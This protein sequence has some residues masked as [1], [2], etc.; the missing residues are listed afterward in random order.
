MGAGDDAG[1]GEGR[2]VAEG[3]L[4]LPYFRDGGASVEIL[5]PAT[6]ETKHAVEVSV[7]KFKGAFA[8]L[9]RRG[10]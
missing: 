8:A 5:P 7:D 9:K 2:G 4:I 1:E 3:S 6:E 10:D